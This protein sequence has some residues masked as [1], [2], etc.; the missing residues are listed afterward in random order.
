MTAT[1]RDIIH[2]DQASTTDPVAR[3]LR[4]RRW[5]VLALAVLLL[6]GVLWAACRLT[7][8]TPATAAISDPWELQLPQPPIP[9]AQYR[10]LARLLHL[11]TPHEKEPAETLVSAGPLRLDPAVRMLVDQGWPGLK[12]AA[13]PAAARTAG[14]V[15]VSEKATP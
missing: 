10:Q 14:I 4:R 5:S 3:R 7:A 6:A 2:H 1:D 8:L 11:E 15:A 12:A 13:M 9:V